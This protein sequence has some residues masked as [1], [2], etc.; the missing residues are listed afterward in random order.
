MGG[1]THFSAMCC[2][3][4]SPV[5]SETMSYFRTRRAV[6]VPLPAPGFP[7]KIMRS[8]LPLGWD[9]SEPE[10]ASGAA[11]E[12]EL[13]R[14][15]GRAVPEIGDVE[16]GRLDVHDRATG[17]YGIIVVGVEVEPGEP[18]ALSSR[19]SPRSNYPNNP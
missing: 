12:R 8:A 13:R 9:E 4:R 17:R 14:R 10:S 3:N 16:K 2:L 19:N 18:A 6:S 15:N 11:A 7:K 5:E 1:Q